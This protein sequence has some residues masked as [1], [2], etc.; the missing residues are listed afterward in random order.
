MTTPIP[1]GPVN[2][3]GRG[4][5]VCTRT[6]GTLLDNDMKLGPDGARW[7]LLDE[8]EIQTLTNTG[9]TYTHMSVAAVDHVCSQK[10]TWA[11]EVFTSSLPHAVAFFYIVQPRALAARGGDDGHRYTYSGAEL[12]ASYQ[13][14]K[15][16]SRAPR[17]WRRTHHDG[18]IEV[19]VNFCVKR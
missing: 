17:L 19:A 2:Q 16:G 5:K 9:A 10:G 12:W 18:A 15:D 13:Y 14:A 3:R 8:A 1:N 11:F 6:G 7:E 4:T